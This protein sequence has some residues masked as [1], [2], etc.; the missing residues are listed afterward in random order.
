MK[1]YKQRVELESAGKHEKAAAKLG[2][3]SITGERT[4]GAHCAVSRTYVADTCQRSGEIRDQ[5]V[6]ALKGE[7]DAAG[8]DKGNINERKDSNGVQHAFIHTMTVQPDRLNLSR[9]E[10]M[11]DFTGTST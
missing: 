5:V 10:S 2:E 6:F 8:Q 11:A 9:L 3:R 4:G 7:Q 1:D